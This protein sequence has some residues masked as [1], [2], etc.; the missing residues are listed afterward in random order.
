MECYGIKMVVPS[1]LC[2]VYNPLRGYVTISESFLKFLVQFLW[3]Q[4]FED[5]L[6]FYRLMVLQVTPN[7][8]AHMIE[9]YVLFMEQ[10]MS[11]P[12]PEEFS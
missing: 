12:T 8:K 6:P 3:N 5:V 4:F 2:K 11:P 10:K 9:L 1:E 7:G